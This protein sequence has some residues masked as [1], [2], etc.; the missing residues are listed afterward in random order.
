M[1]GLVVNFTPF[2]GTQPQINHEIHSLAS[3]D[4]RVGD[5][6]PLG[7]E[8]K[9]LCSDDEISEIGVLSRT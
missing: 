2:L 7:V 9:A 3:Y 5:Y 8:L 1:L 4:T 6:L